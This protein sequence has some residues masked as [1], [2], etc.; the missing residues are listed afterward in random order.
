MESRLQLHI[1]ANNVGWLRLS[2]G[3]Q[4]L[5]GGF[6]FDA[7]VMTGDGTMVYKYKATMYYSDEETHQFLREKAAKP[8]GKKSAS[9]YLYSLVTEER[10]N[11]TTHEKID[12]FI[13]I[14]LYPEFTTSRELRVNGQVTFIGLSGAFQPQIKN[15]TLLSLNHKSLMEQIDAKIQSEVTQRFIIRHDVLYKD[16]FIIAVKTYVECHYCNSSETENLY[17]GTF[18]ATCRIII[19]SK[20]QWNKC[21]GKLDF[22]NLRYF[23][24]EEIAKAQKR[25]P[26]H[27]CKMA[28]ISPRDKIG[29]FFIPV[30]L[31]PKKFPESNAPECIIVK[32][33]DLSFNK[34]RLRFKAMN[35][36]QR[37]NSLVRKGV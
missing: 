31:L 20:V 9:H 13:P 5:S 1:N 6:T 4:Q 27:L 28:E 35:E 24:Y 12:N 15:H 2:I 3:E 10:K 16:A 26:K 8:N 30:L 29:G 19:V 11:G 36:S 14:H 37:K 33:V 21:D 22:E 7:M 18:I 32:G 25:I 34:D 23:K 17:E